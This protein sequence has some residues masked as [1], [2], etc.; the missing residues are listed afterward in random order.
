[1]APDAVP[2]RLTTV[3]AGQGPTIHLASGLPAAPHLTLCRLP[4]AG[5]TSAQRFH[6]LGC[7]ECASRALDVGITSIEDLHHTAVNLPR[8]MAGRHYRRIV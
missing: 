5:R 1:M 3:L 8:F 2:P 7:I 6:R 4:V